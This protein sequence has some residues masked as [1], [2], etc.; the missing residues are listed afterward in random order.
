VANDADGKR[1]FVCYAKEVDALDAAKKL[2]RQMSERDVVAAAMTNERAA[3]YASAVQTLAPFNHSLP[4]VTRVYSSD[5]PVAV[6]D[7]VQR[8]P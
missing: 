4:A 5:N 1:R 7:S 6:S 3:Y 2:A 8:R